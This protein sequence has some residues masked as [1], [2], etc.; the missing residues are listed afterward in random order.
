ML[1][2]VLG[3]KHFISGKRKSVPGYEKLPEHSADI[4]HLK[5]L[6]NESI[7][8]CLN[9]SKDLSVGIALSGGIDSSLVSALVSKRLGKS[10]D[11]FSGTFD[12]VGYDETYYS[13]ILVKANP[14]LRHHIL[15]IDGSDFLNVLDQIYLSQAL[16]FPEGGP[17][18]YGQYKVCE[19]AASL[20]I[21]ALFTGEG[22]DEAFCGYLNLVAIPLKFKLLNSGFRWMGGFWSGVKQFLKVYGRQKLLLYSTK[23]FIKEMWAKKPLDMPSYFFSSFCSYHQE[24]IEML[25]SSKFT[26]EGKSYR[27]IDE[28]LSIFSNYPSDSFI[29]KAQYFYL[30][31]FLPALSMVDEA[32]CKI[33][34]LTQKSPF[35]CK[36]LA[37]YMLSVPPE[38]K[39]GNLELKHVERKMAMDLIPKSIWQRQ[40]KKGFPHPLSKWMWR[41]RNKVSELIVSLS[42]REDLFNK[43]VVLSILD[44]FLL[45]KAAYNTLIFRL[46]NLEFWLRANK[47]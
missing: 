5:D 24:F 6:L 1:G 35:I 18:I 7:T 17:G 37:E 21:D 46:L 23:E 31:Q 28:F 13:K 43:S 44:K 16:E 39:L 4:N 47:E 11:V 36:P 2:F 40:D 26:N 27:V 34:E 25:I 3:P 29:D 8:H 30:T 10:V 22:G 14:L 41:D 33:H 19:K 42:D 38:E 20:G 9:D 45:K 15:R 12:E 32:T